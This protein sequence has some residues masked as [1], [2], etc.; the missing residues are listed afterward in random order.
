[1]GADM[2]FITAGMGGGT[3]TGA[4][5]VI[6]R[7]AKELG[8]LTVAVVTKP[9]MFE[10]RKRQK[11]AEKGLR[12][13]KSSVD[14]LITI[15][16]QRLLNI[17]GQDTSLIDGFKKVDE[18][19]LQAVKG[20]S[21][22]IN[23]TG[24]INLDFADV[25]SVMQNKGVALMGLG[26]GKGENR[27]KDAAMQAMSS[28]LLENI[29]ID[30][31]T[32]IIVNITAGPNLPMREITEATSFVTEA[33]DENADVIFGV[34]IDDK[35]GDEI[36]LTVVATGFS[37]AD[38]DNVNVNM[39]SLGKR[40]FRRDNY[41]EFIDFN[42]QKYIERRR[43]VNPGSVAVTTSHSAGGHSYSREED[44]DIPTFIRNRD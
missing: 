7:V 23:K 40:N 17:L 21:D 2:V 30:G 27:A 14:T 9:F 43:H 25:K 10:G 38:D 35:M 13:L 34:V 18:V 26:S 5:P 3:G 11:Q 12:E 32:G 22:L 16:N 6:A 20:I 42:V 19:L 39:E 33:A 8:I 15:P 44:W 36:R 31:A 4:A 1:T 28:P 41:E 37:V 24:F 29:A